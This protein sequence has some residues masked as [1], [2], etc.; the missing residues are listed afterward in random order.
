MTINTR[1]GQPAVSVNVNKVVLLRNA[2]H[3]GVASVTRVA[4]RCLEAG[5]QGI[6]IHPRRR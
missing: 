5:A 1:V 3:L 6:T 4:Q 2:R